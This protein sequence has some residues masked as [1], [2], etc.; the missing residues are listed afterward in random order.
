MEL[1][2]A[3]VFENGLLSNDFKFEFKQYDDQCEASYATYE[4]MNAYKNCVH[5]LLGPVCEYALGE[6]RAFFVVIFCDNFRLILLVICLA[7]LMGDEK[8][9]M[10]ITNNQVVITCVITSD[11]FFGSNP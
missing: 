5:V 2:E 1:A 7:V 6:F 11:N 3:S 9:K 8:G 4:S 10:F